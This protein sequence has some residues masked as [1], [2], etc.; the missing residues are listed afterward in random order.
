MINDLKYCF[1]NIQ[2]ADKKN[3]PEKKTIN[4]LITEWAGET[5]I[6]N[7]SWLWYLEHSE[8]EQYEYYLKTFDENYEPGTG[9]NNR[10]EWRENTRSRIRQETYPLMVLE[11]FYENLSSWESL[12]SKKRKIKEHTYKNGTEQTIYVSILDLESVIDRQRI[13]IRKENFHIV[14]D[15]GWLVDNFHEQKYSLILSEK[16]YENKEDNYHNPIR[17]LFETMLYFI[18]NRNRQLKN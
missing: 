4:Q 5:E 3:K 8:P 15:Y 18:K 16:D 7:E 17:D 6:K 14:Q 11:K 2:K 12:L 13:K 9:W 1:Q 10:Q